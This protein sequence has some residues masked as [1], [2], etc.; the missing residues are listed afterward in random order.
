MDVAIAIRVTLFDAGLKNDGLEAAFRR[1]SSADLEVLLS[2]TATPTFRI[3]GKRPND[4]AKH[5]EFDFSSLF[6]ADVD[7]YL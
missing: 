7:V 2:G 1:G 4:K 3:K 5:M 6:P